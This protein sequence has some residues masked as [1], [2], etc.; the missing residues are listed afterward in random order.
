MFISV[1]SRLLFPAPVVAII[2]PCWVDEA[3]RCMRGHVE[4]VLRGGQSRSDRI[5]ERWKGY[6]RKGLNTE[7]HMSVF[8][9]GV[10][11]DGLT[12]N[13]LQWGKN[14]VITNEEWKRNRNGWD[15]SGGVEVFRR[16]RDWYLGYDAYDIRAG[17][18]TM[19]WRDSLRVPIMKARDAS[20]I[21]GIS[22]G[23]SWCHV[24]WRIGKLLLWEGSGKKQL[25]ERTICVY[26]R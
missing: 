6:F 14:S 16:R 9:D 2:V 21:V 7:N 4:Y 26:A 15:S 1:G 12:R 19:E 25:S 8:E 5:M 3:L 10:P 24:V 22:C 17:V 18:N 11:N 20:R 13:K 23:L